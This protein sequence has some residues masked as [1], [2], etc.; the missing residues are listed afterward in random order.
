MSATATVANLSVCAGSTLPVTANVSGV[1]DANN[2]F[3]VELSNELGSFSNPT[4]IGTFSTLGANV[5]SCVLP[6][7]LIAGN[8][9]RIRVVAVSPNFVGANSGVFTIQSA[10][11]V[12][13]ALNVSPSNNICNSDVVTFTAA[14]T[15]GGTSPQYQWK[16]N[17]A[18][19]GT[20][21]FRYQTSSLR[22]GD[23][24]YTEMVSNAV[25]ASN[26]PSVSV[27]VSM[28]VVTVPKPQIFALD[29]TLA[30]SATTGNQWFRNGVAIPNA[31]AQFLTTT[32][33]GFYTITVTQ[34]GCS[35]TSDIFSYTPT[36]PTKEL[37]KADYQVNVYP[38]P[39]DG[40]VWIQ[41]KGVDK[42][43]I[44]IWNAIGQVVARQDIT[45]SLT[46][47]DLNTL[48]NGVYYL[49][50]IAANGKL[51]QKVVLQR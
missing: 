33:R 15:N 41:L 38:N 32:V 37:Q 36:T 24:V 35:A 14:P 48:P 47:F 43:T 6:Q 5:L 30:S 7:G 18:N 27:P 23:I 51:I 3:M 26:T 49:H 13:V 34:S 19:V 22:D 28:S 10:P 8:Q 16:L 31:T 50:T 2:G 21:T 1:F 25:C 12:G 9:Y 45:Q 42:A 20:N 17:G 11:L 44:Q 39:T 4:V 40:Q 46:F 29:S